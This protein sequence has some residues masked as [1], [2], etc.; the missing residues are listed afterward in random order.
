M[1]PELKV[2]DRVLI[3]VDDGD[4]YGQTAIITYKIEDDDYEWTV[5]IPGYNGVN[6]LTSEL[7]KV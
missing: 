7:R 6:F 1:D 4:W 5:A 3:L 2:G